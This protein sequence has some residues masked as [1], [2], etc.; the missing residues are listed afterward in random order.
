MRFLYVFVLMF[1]ATFGLAMLIHLFSQALLKSAVRKI[2]VT[3]REEEG[4][5]EFVEQARKAAF[6][7][8]INVIETE[9]GGGRAVVLAKKYDNVHVVGKRGERI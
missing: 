1:L 3:I 4:V 9:N 7:G 5:E 8:D 6:I 2:D